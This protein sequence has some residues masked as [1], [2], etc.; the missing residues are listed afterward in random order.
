MNKSKNLRIIA[1]ITITILA[2]SLVSCGGLSK[3]EYEE[4]ATEIFKNAQ[5]KVGKTQS[6][7][8][9]PE[10]MSPE[11]QKKAIQKFS[12]IFK[13]AQDELDK[14]RPPA[15]YQKGHEHLMK[16]YQLGQEYLKLT[17]E[18][19]DREA[20]GKDIKEIDEKLQK[21][22]KELEGVQKNIRKELPFLEEFLTKE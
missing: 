12:N 3:K 7:M 1:L 15:D 22:E 16:N 19:V 21:I 11:E 5:E 17:A 18:A 8:K 4:K 9:S 20:K 13:E 10:K 14:L 2:T 6:E